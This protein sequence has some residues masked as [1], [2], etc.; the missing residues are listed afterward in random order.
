MAD[1]RR[2][3]PNCSF[4]NITITK[5]SP[6]SDN[7]SSNSSVAND[8]PD[9][10]EKASLRL[11]QLLSELGIVERVSMKRP[12]LCSVQSRLE[13]FVGWPADIAGQSAEQLAQAGFYY[14]G[15]HCAMTTNMVE[16]CYRL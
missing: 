2:H 10:Y 3:F 13:T 6:S 11:S 14:A 12:D 5:Q 8:K 16:W 9:C 4:V 7:S 15:K 1:H